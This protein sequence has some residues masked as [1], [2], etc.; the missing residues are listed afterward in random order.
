MKIPGPAIT[1]LSAGLLAAGCATSSLPGARAH[2]EAPAAPGGSPA[3]SAVPSSQ[4]AMTS[5]AARQLQRCTTGSL[6]I[7]TA[8]RR[9]QPGGR[10]VP[11]LVPAGQASVPGSVAGAAAG[12]DRPDLGSGTGGADPGRKG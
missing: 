10:H 1:L 9:V 5:P 6:R 7:V 2:S 12:H 8:V 11:A 3:A 4:A